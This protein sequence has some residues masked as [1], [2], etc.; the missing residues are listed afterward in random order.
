[1]LKEF[2][3]QLNLD[4]HLELKNKF[5]VYV[6]LLYVGATVF[7]SYLS[8][9]G[10]LSPALWNA[11]FWIILLFSSVQSS[12]KSFILQTR[13]NFIYQFSLVSP[14]ALL[15]AKITYNSILLM[16]V[17]LS[18]WFMFGI[19]F[20]NPVQHTWLYAGSLFMGCIGFSGIL[21]L[22]S[23]IAAR[24]GQNFALMSVLGFPLLIP[25]L[26]SL[27]R[28]SK[29]AMDGLDLSVARTPA[30]LCLSLDTIAI[31]LAFILF[32]YLWRE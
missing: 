5:S 27:I 11:L 22:V 1:M 26:L 14:Q 28:L 2:S 6:T 10:T 8:F 17:A 16:A 23:A 30:M 25:L 18:A 7:I 31:T 20:S 13:G 19:L 15:L 12:A 24:S 9:R 4:I 32:P 29:I 21:T 3:S